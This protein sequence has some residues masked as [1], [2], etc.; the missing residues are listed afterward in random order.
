MFRSLNWER[1]DWKYM[2][3]CKYCNRTKFKKSF[4]QIGISDEGGTA[5]VH[6]TDFCKK[7]ADII[8]KYNLEQNN[9]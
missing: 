9:K 4:V 3:K 1:T 5:G 7:C 6:I 8:K 2:K